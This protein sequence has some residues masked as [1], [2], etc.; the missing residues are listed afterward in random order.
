MTDF[1]E[2]YMYYKKKR[3]RDSSFKD[4]NFP[5]KIGVLLNRD[6]GKGKGYVIG[7]IS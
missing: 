1:G 2:L 4:Q 3:R 5:I 6:V 7:Y